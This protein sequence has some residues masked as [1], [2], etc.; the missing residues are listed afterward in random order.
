MTK[1]NILPNVKFIKDYRCFKEG[2]VVEFPEKLTVIT[3][4]NGAGKSTLLSCIRVLFKN[5]WSYSHNS[6]AK[7]ILEDC[8]SQEHEVA[9][10]DISKD[11]YATRPDLD[12]DNLGLQ[13]QAM[14]G[15]SGQGSMIQLHHTLSECKAPLVILDEP[16]R[17]LAD[18]RQYMIRALIEKFMFENPDTQVIITSHSRI[19]MEMTERVLEVQRNKYIKPDGYIELNKV[20]GE[21]YAK[22]VFPGNKAEQS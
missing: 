16:E 8:I 7:G 6:E 18:A 12:Y 17:G 5:Q 11:L 14:K 9:Y 13:L 4:D 22:Q 15:S 2:T 3:G 20:M 19:F 10:I 1:P 21:F